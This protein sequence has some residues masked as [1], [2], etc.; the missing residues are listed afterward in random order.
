MSTHDAL[1]RILETGAWRD[2]DRLLAADPTSETGTEV[3]RWYRAR[4]AHWTK[5]HQWAGT[6][7]EPDVDPR[8]CLRALAIALATPQQAVARLAKLTWGWQAP[9]S[10]SLLVSL[11]ARRGPDWCAAF[12]AAASEQKVS[13]DD[14]YVIAWVARLALPLVGAGLA[15]LPRGPAFGTAWASHY[16]RGGNEARWAAYREK[17]RDLYRNEAPPAHVRDRLVDRLRADPALAEGL[18]VAI[19]TLGAVGLLENSAAPD[20]ELGPAVA[21]LAD[22]GLLDRTRMIDDV[23]EALTRQDTPA[24][25]KGLAKLLTAC[26]VSGKDLEGRMPLVHGLLATCRGPVTAA[27]LGPALESAGPD[28]LDAIAATVFSRPEKA[29]RTA[30]LKAL[31]ADDAVLRWGRDAVVNAL[32]WAADVPDHAFAS[33]AASALAALDAAPV[34]NEEPPP[35]DLWAPPPVVP[36][37]APVTPVEPTEPGLTAA[38]SRFRVGSDA[39][40][41]ALIWDAVVRWWAR[42]PGEVRGWASALVSGPDVGQLPSAV[43]AAA[44]RIPSPE[45]HQALC[46]AITELHADGVRRHGPDVNWG[47]STL[48]TPGCVLEVFVSETALRLGEIPFLVSTPT[49]SDG[50]LDLATLVGRLRDYGTTPVGPTDLFLALLRLEPSPPQEVPGLDGVRASLW[51]PDRP[52]RWA[53]RR[54]PAPTPLAAELVRRWVTG[55]SLPRFPVHHVGGAVTL[56]PVRL[57]IDLTAVPGMPAELEVGHGDGVQSEYYDWNLTGEVA[58]GVAPAWADLLAARTQRLFDQAG[59]LPPR[60][61]P[62]MAQSPAPGPAV[63]H[64]VAA[65]LCHADEDHRLLAVEAALTLMGRGLWRPEDYTACCA[66][67]LADGVLRLGRLTHAWEQLILAGGLQLLWPTAIVVAGAAS[68]ADRKPPGLADLLGLLRRYV[69]AVPH[70]EVPETVRALAA[71]RGSSKA[72]VEAA[73]FVEAAS[74]AVRT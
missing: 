2:L 41:A 45:E 39:S 68:A 4:R 49:R 14:E 25:Q 44:D 47:L 46:R 55:G 50:T 12:L 37:P 67:M 66:H 18:A 28:D 9:P 62:A 56:G 16:A 63:V 19:A 20:W 70:A 21:E 1:E 61:L 26:G 53:L 29:Q 71:A 15:D 48:S 13:K 72:K 24:T 51:S 30:L 3:R 42:S 11:A 5:A 74:R 10:D 73:A 33:R 7:K 65:T 31:S 58:F 8:A 57:P 23:L 32:R 59:R 34:A 35:T 43:H 6:P 17:H 27:L 52:A 40:D 36:G 60:W 22:E 64:V 69:A 38:L 54:R